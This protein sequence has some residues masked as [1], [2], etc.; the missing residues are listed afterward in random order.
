M[1]IKL[2]STGDVRDV[3]ADVG[4][5]MVSAGL[6]VALTP[7]EANDHTIRSGGVPFHSLKWSARDGEVVS[8]GYQYAPALVWRC[9]TCAQ[10][11][12]NHPEKEPASDNVFHFEKQ[13][14][15]AEVYAAYV[16]LFEAWS[17][18]GSRRLKST[19]ARALDAAIERTKSGLDDRNGG[20]PRNGAVVTL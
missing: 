20:P 11:T 8:G 18:K 16:K 10:I 4:D 19:Y 3:S 6:A 1:K 14:C 12:F 5:M 7:K 9:Q 13:T 15:P 2:H 17:R